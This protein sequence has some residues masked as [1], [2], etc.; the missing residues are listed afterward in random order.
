MYLPVQCIQNLLTQAMIAATFFSYSDMKNLLKHS[1]LLCIH[2]KRLK[3]LENIFRKSK[4][5]LENP[6]Y[7]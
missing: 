5:Y 1:V 6:K 7:I 4:I 3:L 2:K